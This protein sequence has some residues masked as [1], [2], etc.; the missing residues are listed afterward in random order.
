[1]LVN[2]WIAVI[3]PVPVLMERRDLSFWA[4]L[5]LSYRHFHVV[6][7]NMYLLVL[8]LFILNSIAAL[9]LIVPLVVTL[10]LSWFAVRDYTDL[11]L[12]YELD[13]Q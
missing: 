11:L 7:W 1:V 12:E 3:L 8:A 2:Y 5:K 4:A 6:R 10:P 13:R 9:L